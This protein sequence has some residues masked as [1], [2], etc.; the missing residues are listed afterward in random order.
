MSA[1][2]PDRPA[3][4]DP[5]GGVTFRELRAL[6]EASALALRE[7]GVRPGEAVALQTP[8]CVEFATALHGILGAGATV[9]PLNPL[10]TEEE[11]RRAMRRTG[12]R[13]LL[14]VPTARSL[15]A[16]AS[17]PLT[18]S[19]TADPEAAAVL[20]LSSGTTAEPKPVMLSHR[21]LSANIRQTVTALRSNDLDPR[22]SV[23]APLPLSHIYGLNV[24]LHS[25]L[26]NGNHVVL[27]PRFEPR[28]FARLHAEH[29][30]GWSYV[31]P[32][33]VAALDSEDYSAEDFRH[34]RVMLS[35]A[36]DLRPDL[37]RRVGRRL[38]VEIIQGYGMT[39][40]SPV[41]HMMRRGDPLGIGRPVDGTETKIV[42]GE[43]WVRGPQLCSGYL[44]AP[45][46]LVE[47]WLPTG[48]LVAAG[49]DGALRV[50]GRSKELIKYR[51]YQVSPAELEE[52]IAACP[53]VRDVAVTRGTLRG[54]E[55][56]HA[57]VVGT[58][59]PDDVREWVARRVAP[60]K[61]V[62]RVTVVESIPRAATGK[63]LRRL[64]RDCADDSD[65]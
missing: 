22:W 12:A 30:I 1:G 18:P 28:A 32:P 41:T 40:A 16:G 24:L 37:A 56:P 29:R 55:V 10:L 21:A 2:A 62:R 38:G 11:T 43:L 23:L 58:A 61:K 7:R 3:L 59:E 5:R 51:G 6:I 64:L 50:T 42:D 33:I 46:P 8:N 48:D 13:L 53:G 14:D 9:V 63:I 35:G 20:A 34:T 54:E 27:M 45:G 39:E 15:H 52:V 49:P 26:A 25:S 44:D 65:E 17:R 47:G 36:A 60:Y 19:P 4:S 31:A 57:F